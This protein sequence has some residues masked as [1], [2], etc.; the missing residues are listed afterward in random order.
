MAAEA[1]RNAARLGLGRLT[2]KENLFQYEQW[3]Q[4]V[5]GKPSPGSAMLEELNY[6]F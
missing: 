3:F 4:A 5:D 1:R 2:S 6:R